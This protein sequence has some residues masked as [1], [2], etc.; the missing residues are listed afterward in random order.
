[1]TGSKIQTVGFLTFPGFPMA[2]LTSM[3]EPLRAANE[4]VGFEQFAW[5]LVS[6]TGQQVRS[7]AGLM[8]DA[9]VA[10]DATL[11][12]EFLFLLSSPVSR[13][14]NPHRSN[15]ILRALSR[16]GVVI[17]A[18]SGGIFPLARSGL[19]QGRKSAVHW[20]YDAAFRA[21]F[22][23]IEATSDVIVRDGRHY[24]VAGSAAAF[25]LSLQLIEDALGPEVPH[26]VACWFQ[27][28]TM[29]G[30]GVGQM[31]PLHPTASAP[32]PDLVQKAIA[33]FA[34]DME[35]ARS[36]ND[37][38]DHLRV[39]PRQ[40]E[41]AFKRALGQSPSHYFRGLRMKAA[42]QLVRYSATGIADIAFSIGY[43]SQAPLNRHYS[44]QYGLTPAEDRAR[45][46]AFR[47]K[48]K[49]PLPPV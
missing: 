9:P 31:R 3:I 47:V 8:F 48:G 43:A 20:C 45:V 13:F 5:M 30:E 10:L 40:I 49:G 15:S 42:R 16:L 29:R 19:M 38:A 36:V 26:E 34:D 25:D 44:A 27:H 24:T 14:N 33:Y 22:P 28:P 2:C 46:N 11:E 35:G 1:M 6:E 18:V 4:I 23:Q 7:S 37:V 21:E 41:R 32:L 39:T 17:G 12:A